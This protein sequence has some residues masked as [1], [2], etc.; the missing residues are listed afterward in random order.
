MS[1]L[2]SQEPPKVLSVLFLHPQRLECLRC[3][4]HSHAHVTV[5]T[6]ECGHASGSSRSQMAPYFC[7]CSLRNS[8]PLCDLSTRID[9]LL[10]W[11]I[12]TPKREHQG[13]APW[14]FCW[15][16]N[17][18]VGLAQ[19]RHKAQPGIS[20]GGWQKDGKRLAGDHQINSLLR[21]PGDHIVWESEW[22]SEWPVTN[23]FTSKPNFGKADL[24]LRG[25][26]LHV[27]SRLSHSPEATWPGSSPLD[28]REAP[29]ALPLSASPSGF[30]LA[31]RESFLFFLY[32]C[33]F[34]CSSFFTS[35]LVSIFLN[36]QDFNNLITTG[37]IT[38]HLYHGHELLKPYTCAS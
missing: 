20:M 29:E 17:S 10:T 15:G 12:R 6:V 18:H 32:S 16:H 30:T 7:P 27:Q 19:A 4:L 11:Q 26:W 24:S 3:L 23:S 37:F 36:C 31:L 5:S 35:F 33:G 14:S 28:L 8:P 38:T 25:A 34:L 21:M 1:L 22:M 13:Q 9:R 2:L